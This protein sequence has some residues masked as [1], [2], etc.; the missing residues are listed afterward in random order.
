MK[1]VRITKTSAII[2]FSILIF[3]AACG[4]QNEQWLSCQESR[5]W[6]TPDDSKEFYLKIN[7]SK[8]SISV[9]YIDDINVAKAEIKENPKSLQI[10][11]NIYQSAGRADINQVIYLMN[12]KTMT[13][14]K[15]TRAF[16]RQVGSKSEH[17]GGITINKAGNCSISKNPILKFKST[18]L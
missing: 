7:R 1:S 11:V 8:D 2:L 4:K 6:E 9:Q 10:A 15:T 17:I 13:F 12:R 3:S 16:K 5:E 14:S 18:N